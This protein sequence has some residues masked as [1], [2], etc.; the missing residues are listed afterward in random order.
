MTYIYTKLT[1]K[2]FRIPLHLEKK[3]TLPLTRELQEIPNTMVFQGGIANVLPAKMVV[4][5][6][7][8]ILFVILRFLLFLQCSNNGKYVLSKTNKWE[9]E[10]VTVISRLLTDFKIIR[11]I[12][13]KNICSTDCHIFGNMELETFCGKILYPEKI[14]LELKQSIM[15]VDFIKGK[16]ATTIHL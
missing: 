10:S 12:T 3:Y 5:D 9:D 15:A 13:F 2:L 1:L 11:S 4:F 16:I 8:F 6:T 14:L 7:A